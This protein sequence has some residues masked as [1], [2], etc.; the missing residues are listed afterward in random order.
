MEDMKLIIMAINESAFN[1]ATKKLKALG[2]K[3][4]EDFYNIM[5][6]ENVPELT[7][8]GKCLGEVVL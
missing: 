5:L 2:Y 7:G 4:I 3:S 1:L 6:N 8:K